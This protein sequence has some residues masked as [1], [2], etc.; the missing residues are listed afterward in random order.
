MSARQRVDR[1]ALL[2]GARSRVPSAA[3]NPLLPAEPPDPFTARPVDPA[4]VTG[5]DAERL[6]VFEAAMEAARGTAEHSLRASRARFVIEAGTALRGIRDQGLHLVTHPSF[7]DYVQGRWQMDRTRA[8][9]L[10]DACPAMLALSKIFDTP[11]VES[12]ARALAPVLARHG[13]DAVRIVVDTARQESGKVT[14][15]SVSRAAGRLGYIPEQADGGPGED[16]PPPGPD[17]LGE[18]REALAVLRKADRLLS[19]GTLALALTQDRDA[20][21]GI[22]RE[23]AQTARR[24]TARMER[25]AG[26]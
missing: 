19:N 11:P 6:A 10:I 26:H 13:E 2:T 22:A 25:N 16:A 24:I 15:A 3:V 18:L 17:T 7:E 9:Q 4:T 20:A 8:Y 14:A 21:S 23:A 5:T 1:A 12:Q